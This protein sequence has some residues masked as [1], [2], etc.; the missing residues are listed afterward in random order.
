MVVIERIDWLAG[1]FDF[2]TKPDFFATVTVTGADGVQINCDATPVVEDRIHQQPNLQV[3]APGTTVLEP[4]TVAVDVWD[5]D[6]TGSPPSPDP[7]EPAD[8]S[9]GPTRTGVVRGL[10]LSQP[11][12]ITTISGPEAAVTLTIQTQPPLTVFGSPS[13]SPTTFEPRLGGQLTM[14]ADIHPPGTVSLEVLDSYGGRYEVARGD[15]TT[16]ARLSWDGYDFLIPSFVAPYGDYELQLVTP[17]GSVSARVPVKLERQRALTFANVDVAFPA[18]GN[19]Q[20]VLPAITFATPDDADVTWTIGQP[21]AL[22]CKSVGTDVKA[23]VRGATR[24]APPTRLV[25]SAKDASGNWVP[26]GQYCTV[27]TAV[28][29]SDGMAY[30]EFNTATLDIAAPSPIFVEV[31]TDPEIPALVPGAIREVVA[32]ARNAQGA[33]R[34]VARLDV[35]ADEFFPGQTR[36]RLSLIGSC[37]GVAE[38]RVFM[39]L[40][41]KSATMALRA[42]ARDL[43]QLV[44]ADTGVRLVDLAP[45][46]PGKDIRVSVAT[47]AE[48]DFVV[49]LPRT[50]GVDIAFHGSF[51]Q[52]TDGFIDDPSFSAAVGRQ[53]DSAR[54]FTIGRSLD[55]PNGG[56]SSIQENI[57]RTSF[58]AVGEPAVVT[59]T[60]GSIPGAAD[61]CQV[62]RARWS[63]SA[64]V[65]A[66]LHTHGSCRN[67]AFLRHYTAPIRVARVA[68]GWHEL[69]HRPFEE[70][71]EYCCD[72][73]YFQ[74]ATEPNLYVNLSECMARSSNPG[75]CSMIANSTTGQSLPLFISDP[76]SGDVMSDGTVEN[77]DDLRRVRAHY[78]QCARGGC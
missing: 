8:L 19:P 30:A 57:E 64:D 78:A 65:N 72:S 48:G 36:R 29:A 42:E 11:V 76:P 4:Y 13:V 75:T 26:P 6:G 7:R 69:H 40:P 44:P 46:G 37:T 38:C 16:T 63:G 60:G 12:V 47:L 3:C 1:W 28:R 31:R 51:E 68:T 77:A 53:I 74:H 22:G 32:R 67:N 54:G 5:A 18:D 24:S 17:G 25:W 2:L 52:P 71:D 34:T 55:N 41:S 70:A 15:F 35:F 56:P 14:T 39:P 45:G 73:F 58:W 43:D 49:E 27:L 33:P 66:V 61:L 9:W 23:S 21:T 10:G 62:V 50:H 59:G 20:A